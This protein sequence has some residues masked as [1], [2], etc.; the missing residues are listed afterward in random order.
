MKETKLSN[1]T[2]VNKI[3]GSYIS[4]P[5]RESYATW[6]GKKSHNFPVKKKNKFRQYLISNAKLEQDTQTHT[7]QII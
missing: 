5:K 2:D 1:K 3:L 4:I 7:D 6:F